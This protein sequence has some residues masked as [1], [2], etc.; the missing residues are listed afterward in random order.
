MAKKSSG[1]DPKDIASCRHDDKDRVNN[2]PVG[3]VTPD[4]EKELVQPADPRGQ[5]PGHEQPD[6]HSKNCSFL[7]DFCWEFGSKL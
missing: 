3:L 7:L 1:K 5:P 4:T 6:L 2:P